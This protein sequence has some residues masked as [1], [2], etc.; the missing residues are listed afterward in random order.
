MIHELEDKS[1]MSNKWLKIFP[2]ATRNKVEY[3]I[4]GFKAFASI[5]DALATAKTNEHYIY[6]LGWMIDVDFALTPAN[7]T[8]T[9]F[10]LLSD[11]AQKGVE[12][13][14]LVWY[15]PSKTIQQTIF[16]N[17]PRL[18]KLPNTAAFIDDHTFTTPESVKWV[19]QFTPFIIKQYSR[20]TSIFKQF[21]PLFN[22]LR[23][24]I[25]KNVGSHHDKVIIVKGE[26]G[27]IGF[28]GGM[29]INK[30][31]FP[32]FTSSF[33]TFH[34]LQCKVIG[35][36]ANQLLEKF[37]RRWLN[38]PNAKSKTL[39]G[40][41]EA[42][43]ANINTSDDFKYAKVVGTF[44]D[45]DSTYRDRSLK[46]AYLKIIANAEK[47]IYIED[48]YLVNLDVAKELNK[49][50]KETNFI[51]LIMAVQDSKE[52]DDILIPDRKRGEFWYTVID[53]TSKAEQ[54]KASLVLI[55]AKGAKSGN[56]H[57]GLHAKFLCVDDEIVIIGTANVNQRS[58]TFD[59]ETS[60]VIFDDETKV[61][62]KV[63]FAKQLRM[64]VWQEFAGKVALP[65]GTVDSWEKYS[66][67]L[68]PSTAK[69]LILIPYLNSVEDLDKQV[70]DYLKRP[71]IST[72]APIAANYLVG[73]DSNLATALANVSIVLS[74]FTIVQT[75]DGLWDNV[76]DPKGP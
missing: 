14:I 16:N 52:T 63:S 46:E 21:D 54:D 18:N 6:I 57:A 30:N 72:I 68:A 27:L 31:R 2:D 41:N 43:S 64:E 67:Y 19:S 15:N 5:A 71:D 47:Y 59:S 11:A 13:R 28:C 33:T 25:T 17:I 23:Y 3:L 9:L 10:K 36:A 24:C 38:H 40:S 70:I 58:F 48:Q 51:K 74:P 39:R 61:K 65:A 45:P 29:D 69:P 60:V 32:I 8:R 7:P 76:I 53:N 55:D 4:D 20:F 34:D 22:L 66:T 26:A 1:S 73:D 12:I 37:K 35:P 49:K 44:N 42:M 56:Y 62:G 50:I 75:F